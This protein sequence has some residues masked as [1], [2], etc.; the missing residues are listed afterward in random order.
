[1]HIPDNYTL[2]RFMRL[3]KP[4]IIFLLLTI[5]VGFLSF[6][7]SNFA[8]LNLLFTDEFWKIFNALIVL[9]TLAVVAYYTFETHLLRIATVESNTLFI[10]PLVILNGSEGSTFE[11]VS[12]GN[13]IAMNLR[14]FVW[15]GSS[16]KISPQG[17]TVSSL[18][19]GKKTNITTS[20][21]LSPNSIASEIP[22]CQR[23]LEEIS[24]EP[25]SLIC[26][27]YQDI[28]GRNLYSIYKT[29]STKDEPFF[30]FGEA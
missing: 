28:N 29:N 11:L 8:S 19:E 20:Q 16:F 17:A 24:R 27:I 12:V 4:M 22:A 10:R 25:N 13:G 14:V 18:S 3:A 30:R 7:L 21:Q 23:I 9:A 2:R 26:I 5:V 15:D 1:M 6:F